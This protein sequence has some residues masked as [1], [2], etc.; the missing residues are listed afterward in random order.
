ML[1]VVGGINIAREL[2][3]QRNCTSRERILVSFGGHIE[4]RNLSVIDVTRMVWISSKPVKS[5]LGEWK[6]KC[7]KPAWSGCTAN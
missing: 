1:S 4:K 6:A 2:P 3:I 5:G 7:G